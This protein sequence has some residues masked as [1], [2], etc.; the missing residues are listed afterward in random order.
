MVVLQKRLEE[1]L[2]ELLARAAS[3]PKRSPLHDVVTELEGALV[4]AYENAPLGGIESEDLA[5]RVMVEASRYVDAIIDRPAM[6]AAALERDELAQLWPLDA[7]I[8]HAPACT[9]DEL[10]LHRLAALDRLHWPLDV[11]PLDV[12]AALE[13]TNDEQA[14]TVARLLREGRIV[15][16]GAQPYPNERAANVVRDLE[17][18]RGG[19][20]FEIR[21]LPDENDAK[22][23][24]A[25]HAEIEATSR[26]S[27]LAVAI[28]LH[29]ERRVRDEH[30][31]ARSFPVGTSKRARA[32][33]AV[34]TSGASGPW[35]TTEQPNAQ[36]LSPKYAK[37][38]LELVW[39]GKPQ[40]YQLAFSNLGED[41]D[42]DILKSILKETSEDGLRDYHILHR[43]AAEQG[44]SGQL[45]WTWR[46]HRE[47]SIYAKR[48]AQKNVADTEQALAVTMRLL[49]FKNA[50]I[51]EL[52]AGPGGAT[53]WRRIGPFGLIDIPGAI[54][55]K[56]A[57]DV[58]PIIF[59]PVLY[60]SVQRDA[61]DPHFTLLPDSVTTL[62]GR[63]LRLAT[64]LAVE[65]RYARDQGGELVR[66]TRQ[67]WEW[68]GEF[69]HRVPRRA[70]WGRADKRLQAALDRLAAEGVIGGWAREDGSASPALRYSIRPSQVWRDQL[71]HRLV[72]QFP[73]SRADVPRTG[74]ALREWRD[75][76]GVSQARA[77][78]L[79]GVSLRTLKYAEAKGRE[80]EPLRGAIADALPSVVAVPLALTQGQ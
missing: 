27:P 45:I 19:M 55:R 38:R 9:A 30:A 69:E 24:R 50:E 12:I 68:T 70:D 48:I 49:R 3:E 67:L 37:G 61:K 65:M 28:V 5:A 58:V 40:A 33:L 21:L 7:S 34:M 60:E 52:G 29:V 22:A 76:R 64:M 47:R 25:H 23:W 44:R 56:G 2:A 77:A 36:H 46:E 26:W 51:R 59:N 41:L 54:E 15:Y 71:V 66:R 1:R 53:A 39:D 31:K 75:G 11:A 18:L 57:F 63:L 14:A 35:I 10:V 62:D 78:E 32:V 8:P 72:P 17:R 43:M 16:A 79:L 74:R 42:G 13:R 6:R 4:Y 73:A 20:P 80:N